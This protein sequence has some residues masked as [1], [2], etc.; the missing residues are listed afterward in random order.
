MG[1]GAGSFLKRV[2]KPTAALPCFSDY[3]TLKIA[4]KKGSKIRVKRAYF[5][6]FVSYNFFIFHEQFFSFL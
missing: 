4:L 1:T 6:T 5:R 2:E 3:K